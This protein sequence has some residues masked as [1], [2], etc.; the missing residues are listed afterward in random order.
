MAK[1]MNKSVGPTNNVCDGTDRYWTNLIANVPYSYQYPYEVWTSREWQGDR[2]DAWRVGYNELFSPY[3]SPSTVD[4]DNNSTGIFIYLTSMNGNT[5]NLVIYKV[6][7]GGWDEN[8][9]LAATPPTKPMNLKS[10]FCYQ[11]TS[12]PYYYYNK[13][14]WHHNMEPDMRRG[15]SLTGYVKRYNIYK[16]TSADMDHLPD[17]NNYS[18]LTTIDIDENVTP[19]YIDYSEPSGCNEP[20]GDGTL[21]ANMLDITSCQI[22]SSSS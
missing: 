21:S 20:P 13:I 7:E 8:E 2:W 11:S 5:A 19:S 22:S 15:S 17:E 3:S 14:T 16:V 9:I 12:F 1:N 18:L 4:W 10:E 6:G